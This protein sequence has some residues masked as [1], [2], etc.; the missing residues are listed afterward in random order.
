MAAP[1]P[2]CLAADFLVLRCIGLQNPLQVALKHPYAASRLPFRSDQVR[3]A[4]DL[5]CH[6]YPLDLEGVVIHFR[7]QKC[8]HQS[9]AETDAEDYRLFAPLVDVFD[10]IGQLREEHLHGKAV[11]GEIDIID[12]AVI[13][14]QGALKFHRLGSEE[15]R[16]EAPCSEAGRGSWQMRARRWCG[17]CPFP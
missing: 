1:G 17:G 15:E 10:E 9:A 5:A 2:F 12:A 13:L 6:H 3:G 14:E 11:T 7:A 16:G 8:V 4:E